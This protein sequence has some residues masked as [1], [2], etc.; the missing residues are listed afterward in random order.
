MHTSVDISSDFCEIH[1][2]K[3]ILLPCFLKFTE[4]E[5]VKNTAMLAVHH[6]DVSVFVY[7][8]FLWLQKY[9]YQ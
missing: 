9:I 5:I 8:P 2:L 1:F 4:S 3:F 7:G 6:Y